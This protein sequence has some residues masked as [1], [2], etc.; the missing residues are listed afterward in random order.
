M[1][2]PASKLKMPDE[3]LRLFSVFHMHVN[4]PTHTQTHTEHTHTEL[5]QHTHTSIHSA[6]TRIHSTHTHRAYTEIGRN[7][8]FLCTSLAEKT[9][10]EKP[11]TLPG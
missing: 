8:Q 7:F 10:E 6:H 9:L 3:H 5:T 11:E 4:I 2:D 1:R